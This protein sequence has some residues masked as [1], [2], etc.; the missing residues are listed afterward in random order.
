[1]STLASHLYY[2]GQAP[3][4]SSKGLYNVESEVVDL[5]GPGG[6]EYSNGL[7][8]VT[9]EPSHQAVGSVA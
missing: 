4:I 5:F 3:V 2:V 6:A 9:T 7:Y 1:M 8:S